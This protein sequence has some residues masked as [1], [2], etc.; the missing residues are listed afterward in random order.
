MSQACATL[1]KI[2]QVELQGVW[3]VSLFAIRIQKCENW[4]KYTQDSIQWNY[5]QEPML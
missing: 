1:N 5:L 3:L 2:E 4:W